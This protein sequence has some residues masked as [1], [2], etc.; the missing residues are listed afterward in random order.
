[1]VDLLRYESGLSMDHRLREASG[2]QHFRAVQECQRGVLLLTPH[3]G[4][5]EFGAPLLARRGIPLLVITLEEPDAGLTELRRAAR[6][7]RGVETLVIGQDPFAFVE[8]IRRLESG[9]TVAL[10][11]DRPLPSSAVEVELFGKPFPASIAA[12]ELARASGC[13]LLPV[14]LPREQDGYG[15]QVLPAIPYDRRSLNSREAR[16]NLTQV[17]MRAFEP[18]IQQYLAQWYHFVPIW[19]P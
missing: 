14:V 6:A 17:I 15:A 1:M 12:A 4:N 18:V 7:R 5:W 10:L 8:V 2:W 13:A 9:A 3:I 16:R 11:I 19:R